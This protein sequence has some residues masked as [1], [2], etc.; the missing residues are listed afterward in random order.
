M[1]AMNVLSNIISFCVL[2]FSSIVVGIITFFY[3][4]IRILNIFFHCCL[5]NNFQ[6]LNNNNIFYV[7]FYN[8]QTCIFITLKIEQQYLNTITEQRHELG[9]FF[10]TTFLSPSYQFSYCPLKFA[11]ILSFHVKAVT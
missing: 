2:I 6:Y 5:N 11:I 7:Y 3:S 4:T 8:I 10:F 1:R 9:F